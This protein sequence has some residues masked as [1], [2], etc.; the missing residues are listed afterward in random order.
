[1]VDYNKLLEQVKAQ[2]MN[3]QPVDMI[4]QQVRNKE[5]ERIDELNARVDN[6]GA[7]VELILAV[8]QNGVHANQTTPQTFT[9][10]ST[11][12]APIASAPSIIDIPSGFNVPVHTAPAAPVQLVYQRVYQYESSKGKTKG[13]KVTTCASSIRGFAMNPKDYYANLPYVMYPAAV[14]TLAEDFRNLG[15]E[16]VQKRI[17]TL[18]AGLT[19]NKL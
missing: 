11:P 18:E 1:M 10:I 7:G 2:T 13:Q 3:K 12:A 19:A 8:L 9:P 15:A 4:P 17:F 5:Q 16:E 6:I 14:H